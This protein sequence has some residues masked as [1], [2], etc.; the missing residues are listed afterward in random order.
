MVETDQE[1][2]KIIQSKSG[3]DLAVFVGR[4]QHDLH[5]PTDGRDAV[6]AQA[7]HDGL[8]VQTARK[9]Q[10]GEDDNLLQVGN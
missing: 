7:A 4:V 6:E 8:V 2:S 5:E 9:K 1:T 3:K 10:G